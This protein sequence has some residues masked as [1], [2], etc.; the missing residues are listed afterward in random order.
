VWGQ[1]SRSACVELGE[2]SVL[3]QFVQTEELCESWIMRGVVPANGQGR[4]VREERVRGDESSGFEF[5]RSRRQREGFV[6][7]S[8]G[9]RMRWSRETPETAGMIGYTAIITEQMGYS[10]L[11]SRWFF[12][13]PV[14]QL[15]VSNDI[16]PHLE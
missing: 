11:P 14:L 7:A 8:P 1:W 4:R 10:L 6:F 13:L 2:A 15:I 5:G 3:R 12:S 16:R 9:W